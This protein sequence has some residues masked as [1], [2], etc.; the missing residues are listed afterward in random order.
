M[1]ADKRVLK[2]ALTQARAEYSR[3]RDNVP[4][5]IAL[6]KRVSAAFYP[7]S[8]SL[9]NVTI[10]RADEARKM[11]N[12]KDALRTLARLTEPDSLEKFQAKYSPGE[13]FTA[14]GMSVSLDS[15]FE[16]AE[17]ALR[18]YDR[19]MGYQ[20]VE[21]SFSHPPFTI[22]NHYGFKPEEYARP[23]ALLDKVS[24]VIQGAGF[25]RILYGNVHLV[26]NKGNGGAQKFC[27]LYRDNDDSV[28]LNVACNFRRD[29]IHTLVHEFGH[30]HW[31]KVLTAAQREIYEEM[32]A[33]TTV[34]LPVAQRER[35]WYAWKA[36]GY[37]LKGAA[38]L[39]PSDEAELFK[40]YVKDRAS[41]VAVQPLPN[42]LS[43]D[44]VRSLFVMPMRH[45]YVFD[46]APPTSVSDY[47]SSHVVEDYAEV[48]AYVLLGLRVNDD[49]RARFEHVNGSAARI[50]SEV[51]MDTPVSRVAERFLQ[52]SCLVG[53][54][55]AWI[56]PEGKAN[57]VKVSHVAW[58]RGYF[59]ANHSAEWAL[60]LQAFD[61]NEEEAGVLA[62][63]HL[64]D[65]GWIRV[66]SIRDIEVGNLGLVKQKAWN[67]LVDM[68]I[69]CLSENRRDPE[70]T[71][72]MLEWSNGRRQL[73]VVDFIEE[74]GPPRATD[75]LFETLLTRV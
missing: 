27:G 60:L 43:E 36:S 68:M 64:L 54:S 59:K 41:A 34:T 72:I 3:L 70:K 9:D 5:M 28:S 11:K 14:I 44:R 19:V 73:S 15:L 25:G 42:G 13:P 45:R 49:A 75:R 65:N 40:R 74:Y 4:D 6:Y 23:L 20:Q 63:K 52:A 29:E 22:L 38:R 7:Y 16:R 56:S 30:R 50:A 18:Y 2:Q 24:S 71:S 57:I 21:K 62:Q 37:D 47:G 61:G 48:F 33:G 39:V 1:V 32:Y 66:A 12:A 26:D 17:E 31:F 10:Q 55:W 69:E 46:D 51:G 67:A 58:A 53:V 35:F 8:K